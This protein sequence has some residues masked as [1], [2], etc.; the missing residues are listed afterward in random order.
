MKARFLYNNLV[1]RN[2]YFYITRIHFSSRK[3]LEGIDICK[4]LYVLVIKTGIDICS[5]YMFLLVKRTIFAVCII[6]LCIMLRD[7]YNILHD[8][9]NFCKLTKF[10]MTKLR[11]KIINAV[12]KGGRDT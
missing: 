10:L 9:H 12:T 7:T 5:I 4:I 3:A 2:H 6:A 8:Q 1:L 11:L